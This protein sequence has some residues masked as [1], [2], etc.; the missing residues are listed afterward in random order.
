M[1]EQPAQDLLEVALTVAKPD[2][3]RRRDSVQ[4]AIAEFGEQ[5][6]G[7]TPFGET[8]EQLTAIEAGDRTV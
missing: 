6:Q 1:V 5:L 4:L 3:A 7:V 2:R 8:R